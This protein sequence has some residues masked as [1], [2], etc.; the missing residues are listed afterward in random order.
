[1]KIL[2]VGNSNLFRRKILPA[3]ESIPLFQSVDLSSNHPINFTHRLI[4]NQFD[5]HSIAITSTEAELV[6]IST[7]NESHFKWA[8]L[9]LEMGKHLIVDKPLALTFLDRITLVKLAKEKNVLLS[10]AVVNL[11]HKQFIRVKQL[12]RLNKDIP[13]Y[14]TTNF[15]VPPFQKDNFRNFKDKGG[16]VFYDMGIY[17]ITVGNYFFKSKP[18]S[19]STNVISMLND[20]EESIHM[21]VLYPD[22]KLLSAI[23]S[24]NGAYD[25]NIR[26][27]GKE[28]S[29]KFD[30]VYSIPAN[31]RNQIFLYQ[32][33]DQ[34][35]FEI[36][37][38]DPFCNY[39]KK[40]SENIISRTFSQEYQKIINS[41]EIFK[42][43]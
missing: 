16:G 15:I 10:E 11:Y 38:D 33:L 7:T 36:E 12:F 4:E 40:M 32:N 18:I 30:R 14:I 31:T 19:I 24:F 20:V 39:F 43:K 29:I 13:K 5:S 28:I 2:I 37:K 1:M 26:I 25:N 23:F 27:V 34:T 17:A 22:N 21:M 42:N 41:S 8:K 9:S 3:I 35:K 6:Y